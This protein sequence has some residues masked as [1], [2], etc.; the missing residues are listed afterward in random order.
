MSKEIARSELLKAYAKSGNTKE[1]FNLLPEEFI[2]TSTKK[3]VYAIEIEKTSCNLALLNKTITPQK[4]DDWWYGKWIKDINNKQDG[5]SL[6]EIA[7]KNGHVDIVKILVKTGAKINNDIFLQ[8]AGNFEIFKILLHADPAA[9]DT[10]KRNLD[11][12][13]EHHDSYKLAN[14]IIKYRSDIVKIITDKSKTGQKN[15][16]PNIAVII[17]QIAIKD[18]EFKKPIFQDILIGTIAVFEKNLPL[19]QLLAT[20][21]LINLFGDN[22]GKGSLPITYSEAKEDLLKTSEAKLRRDSSKSLLPKFKSSPESQIHDLIDAQKQ[23]ME[24]EFV[25]TNDEIRKFVAVESRSSM[26]LDLK[27]PKEKVLKQEKTVSFTATKKTQDKENKK[28]KPKTKSKEEKEKTLTF[29]SITLPTTTKKTYSNQSSLDDSEE[30][31]DSESEISES[32]SEDRQSKILQSKRPSG[33]T[34]PRSKDRSCFSCL[35][36]RYPT[37]PNREQ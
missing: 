4:Y 13:K 14:R 31:S 15:L 9:L 22:R 26:D 24:R 35:A 25:F 12:I 21:D 5:A 18:Q 7:I 16:I 27:D 29:S 37:S 23:K 33:T 32:D 6:L 36:P 8:A 11:K 30:V 28:I 34:R 3:N 2:G 1:F 17:A 20:E 19:V 10:N